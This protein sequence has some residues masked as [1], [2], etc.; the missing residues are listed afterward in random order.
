MLYLFTT[1]VYNE[2]GWSQTIDLPEKAWNW[3]LSFFVGF[4]VS[5]LA[6]DF[7]LRDV[8]NNDDMVSSISSTKQS[9]EYYSASTS[10]DKMHRRLNGTYSSSPVTA[11]HHSWSLAWLSDFFSISALEVDPKRLSR[12]DAKWLKRRGFTQGCAFWSKNRCF[13]YP[14]SPGPLKAQ[15]F[16]NFWLRKN[17]LDLANIRFLTPSSSVTLC[18]TYWVWFSLHWLT[19]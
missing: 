11:T 9:R 16:E 10:V 18:I 12:N 3:S 1:I 19:Q 17:W 7:K 8:S 6:R 15:T 14:R 4:C 13:S 2:H 5:V